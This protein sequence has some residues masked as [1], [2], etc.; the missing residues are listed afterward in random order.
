MYG[1]P[2]DNPISDIVIHKIETYGQEIDDLIREVYPFNK[3]QVSA[4]IEQNFRY[5]IDID[6]LRKQL[7]LLRES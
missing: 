3:R 1:R 5:E 6:E 4:L 2:G 7:L